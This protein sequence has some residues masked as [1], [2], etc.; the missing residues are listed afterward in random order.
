M[1]MI[2]NENYRNFPFQSGK[3]ACRKH[4][5]YSGI[6]SDKYQLEIENSK[7]IVFANISLKSATIH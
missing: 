6:F 5:N 3:K 4:G 7:I 1:Q 2:D